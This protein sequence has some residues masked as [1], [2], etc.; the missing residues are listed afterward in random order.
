MKNII[1][2]RIFLWLVLVGIVG[3]L[4][5]M[6]I[7]PKGKISY[8]YDFTKPSYF[9]GKLTPEE[10][11]EEVRDGH[12]KIIGDPVYFSLHTPRRFNKVKLTLRYKQEEGSIPLPTTLPIIEAGILVDKTIW[13]YDLKPLENRIINQLS[14]TWD[15]IK[16]NGIILLQ[17]EKKFANI[18]EFLNNLPDRKEVAL[19]N[20]DL[21]SEFLIPNYEISDKENK[22]T[23][24][25]RGPYQFY[26]YIK[27]ENL[28]FTFNFIDINKNRD[29][30]PIDLHLY[31]DNELIDSRHLDD[32]GI[33]DDN[34]EISSQ[35][36]VKI[37]LANLPEGVYKIE[38]KANDDII[39]KKIITKQSKLS[40][41]N[42]IWLIDAPDQDISLYSDSL[43][44]QAQTINPA[45][46]QTIKVGDS[47]LEIGETYK[48]FS[49]IVGSGIKEIKLV[50]D[51][52]ILSGDGVFS[53][54]QDALINPQFK[55]V[56][57]NL[58]IN[59]EGINYVLARYVIPESKG[60]WKIAQA[61][62]NLTKAYQED[63]K[64]SFLISIPGLRADDPS[65][66]SPR[67]ELGTKAGQVV[68]DSI[69][70]DE[71]R[72]ELEGKSLFEKLGELLG[73]K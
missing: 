8:V 38:I 62:F 15:M 12:Q 67:P 3:W 6:G 43:S 20:Y 68:E 37:K 46:L 24:A 22:I 48:L 10:R 41:I 59:E 5:Y 47:E 19:Y 26:T 57:A 18:N 45:S 66:S 34:N 42:K 73:N 69:E 49:I 60:E 1:K 4:L 44:L 39:T 58:N 71:I 27:N 2:I 70:I 64:Y 16:E 65:A 52:I 13:R 56:S 7:V 61:E 72:V 51:D 21:K 50:H 31:Y 30:D 9:I 54:S 25:L 40:F 29:S 17:K 36:E 55:K 33:T 11:V 23:Y 35:S 14:L 63:N 28:D 53:F 32:D